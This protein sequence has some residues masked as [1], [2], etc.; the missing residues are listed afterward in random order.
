[1]PG[2]DQKAIGSAQASLQKQV[3][4]ILY[5][6]MDSS[7]RGKRKMSSFLFQ[8]QL[9]QIYIYSSMSTKELWRDTN[10]HKNGYLCK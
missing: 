10:K 3:R 7:S 9:T 8:V 5:N 6:M 4:E 2:S 1:M